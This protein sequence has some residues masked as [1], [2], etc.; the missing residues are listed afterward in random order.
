MG[1]NAFG[2]NLRI[3]SNLD[4]VIDGSDPSTICDTD[5]FTKYTF[6]IP[7][8]GSSLQLKI[9]FDQFGGT[10]ES[11]IDL[12]EIV[13][14]YTATPTIAT[15]GTLSAFTSCS[16]APSTSQNFSVSATNLT[17][18]LVVTAPT[19]FEVSLSSGSGY[20]SSVSLTPSSGHC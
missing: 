9:D 5:V 2:G 15:T 1:D 19:G 4:G 3:D 18:N 8:T 13:G 12:I 16:G 7:N 10:E 17:N 14:T 20:N 11:A 6:N